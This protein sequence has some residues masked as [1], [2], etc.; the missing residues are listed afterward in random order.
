VTEA[1]H[2]RVLVDTGPLVAL[3]DRSD[4]HHGTCTEALRLIRPPLLTCWP[5]LTEVAWLLRAHP[6]Q[7]QRLYHSVDAGLLSLLPVDAAALSEIGAL[8][9]R[10]QSLRPQL[11]D[12]MLWHLVESLDLKTIFTL[13]RRD[14]PAFQ[15]RD[16]R[17]VTLLP[18]IVP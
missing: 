5:V 3:L 14:F 4:S 1:L 15:R 18:E 8:Y 9:Q 2:E 17:V 10:F 11:A 12:L 7:L 16:R 13:D 6:R